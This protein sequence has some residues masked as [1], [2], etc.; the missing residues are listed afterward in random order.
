MHSFRNIFISLLVIMLTACTGN[1]E[2][3]FDIHGVWML[4]CIHVPEGSDYDYRQTGAMVPVK[5]FTDS[6]YYVGQTKAVPGRFMVSPSYSGSYKLIGKGY[7]EYLYFEDGNLHQFTIINDSIIYIKDVGTVHEWKKMNAE[8]NGNVGDILDVIAQDKD[9]WDDDTRD[10]VFTETERTLKS[11]NSNLITL[12]L[13]I[14]LAFTLLAYFT[15]TIYQNK[16][17]A[18]Q[19]LKQIR[20]EIDARP[21]IVQQAMKSVEE[22][23]LHSDFYLSIRRRISN[24]ERLNPDDWDAVEHQVNSTYPGFTNRLFNLHPMSQTEMQTCLLIKLRVP[25]TE[26]ANTLIKSTSTISSTRSRLYTKVFH[27]KGGAK[28]WDDFILSL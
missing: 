1:E 10:Y 13:C 17:R 15:H 2:G 8:T 24:G 25:A 11:E 26:I 18:E 23:F 9:T 19:Q 22:E 6:T 5:I 16:K 12:I 27:G 7:N 4:E 28:E 3:H 14:I 21:E 20:Q